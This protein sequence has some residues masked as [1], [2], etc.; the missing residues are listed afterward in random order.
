[1]HI[2]SRFLLPVALTVGLLASCSAGDKNEASSE[3]SNATN[4]YASGNNQN[5]N[6]SFFNANNGLGFVNRLGGSMTKMF[7]VANDAGGSSIEG[8]REDSGSVLTARAS[9]RDTIACDTGSLE[10]VV[11]TDDQ[12]DVPNSFELIFNDCGSPGSATS[13][14]ISVS[15]AGDEQNLQLSMTL[16]NFTNTEGSE[17]SS[18]DGSININVT[19]SGGVSNFAVSGPVLTMVA[20]GETLQFSNYS[21]TG[22]ENSAAQT[23]S[24]AASA[25]IRSSTDGDLNMTIDPPFVSQGSAIEYPSS[26]RMTMIHSDGSQL[27][28][29]ADNGSPESFD[30][31]INDNGTVTSGTELW[32]N[33][34]LTF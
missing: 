2:I 14:S 25:S 1:M 11:T 12:T 22:T 31:V 23:S 13:G 26:G 10:T 29:Q 21:L 19:D 27:E 28:I 32:D 6:G 3:S 8:Y 18:M 7:T 33:T 9:Q 17:T 15:L 5:S 16:D 30:Y 4:L 24:L 20:E 34:D